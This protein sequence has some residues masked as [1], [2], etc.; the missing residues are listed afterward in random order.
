MRADQRQEGRPAP[1]LT[2][3]GELCH[4]TRL[5]RAGWSYPVINGTNDTPAQRPRG[6]RKVI[7][8]S[9]SVHQ[10]AAGFTN[11]VVSKRNG[12]IELDP[13]VDG[14]CKLTLSENEACALRDA[15]TEWLG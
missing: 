14:S 4:A 2:L 7:H 6:R 11:L 1:L 12:E 3:R 15:L 9:C 13:H 10:G 5:E 8:A